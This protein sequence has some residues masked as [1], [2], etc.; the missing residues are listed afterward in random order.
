MKRNYYIVAL[1]M[2]TFFVISFITNIIGPLSPEFINNFK[3]SNLLAGVLPFAF[4]IAY[5]VMSIPTSMLVQ[6]YGEKTIMVAAFIVAFLGSLLLAAQPNY[7]TAI[8]SL[9][10]IGCGMAMLQVVINPLLRTAGGEENYAFTSVL[11]QLIFGG[12][13]YVSPLVYSYLVLNLNKHNSTGIFSILQPL[14]PANL[15]WIS[16]YWLFTVICIFMFAIM[17]ISKFP[18]VDLAEDEKAGPWKTHVQLFK[19]PVVILYFIALFCY[20]GTEQGVSY[21]MSQFLFEYHK[22]DPQVAGAHAVSNFWGLMLVGGILGLLLLKVMDSRK[23]LVLFTIPAIILLSFALFGSAQISLYCFPVIG[24]FM[25]VMY[26]IIFSLALS[27][28]SEDHGSFA[29]ILVTGI[30]G[31]AVVQLLIG[32]L[33]NLIG[34]K[35]GMM[36]LYITFGYMLSIGFWAKPLITNKTVFDKNDSKA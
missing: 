34:L 12:A 26:P 5:G 23:L 14:V 28:V 6:K 33:G 15:P 35:G 17:L 24:F 2:L 9:F 25:S 4:F 27:S 30:I 8:L 13:S 29:G 11:A 16:L 3:L 36:V 22:F 10:L 18:K 7:L 20:V 31:G 19:K 21:W 1:I 32:G